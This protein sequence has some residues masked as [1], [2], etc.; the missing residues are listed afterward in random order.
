MEFLLDDVVNTQG[1][2]ADNIVG[3]VGDRDLESYSIHL[4]AEVD[5]RLC[6]RN[7]AGRIANLSATS[8]AGQKRRRKGE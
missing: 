1:N 8:L 2:I 7:G 3:L 4:D 6:V 5:V